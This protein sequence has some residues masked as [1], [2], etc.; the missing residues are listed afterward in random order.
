MIPKEIKVEQLGEETTEEKIDR[1]SKKLDKS[2][3]DLGEV[4]QKMKAY[5]TFQYLKQ[6]IKGNLSTIKFCEEE[7]KK[8]Q[9]MIDE[10]LEEK[11]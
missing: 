6:K 3:D 10:I 8:F 5:K 1:L 2:I 11:E 4:F 9:E 7:N